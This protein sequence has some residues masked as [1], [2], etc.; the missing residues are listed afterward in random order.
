[1]PLQLHQ[2]P[3]VPTMQI[4]C[5]NIEMVFNHGVSTKEQATPPWLSC[6]AIKI[7]F[8]KCGMPLATFSAFC[9]LLPFQLFAA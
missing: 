1:L 8:S 5:W 9:R 4:R 2:L 7:R 6:A 3:P